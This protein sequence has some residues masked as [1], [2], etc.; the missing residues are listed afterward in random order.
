ML[1]EEHTKMKLPYGPGDIAIQKGSR[2]WPE[3][4]DC[5][6]VILFSVHAFFCSHPRIRQTLGRPPR[7]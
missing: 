6:A 1:V 2:K 3:R 4:P 5:S 7:S